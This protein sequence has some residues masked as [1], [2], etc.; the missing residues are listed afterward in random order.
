MKCWDG[1]LQSSPSIRGLGRGLAQRQRRLIN[2]NEDPGGARVPGLEAEPSAGDPSD[3]SD[4][5]PPCRHAQPVPH[6]AG[7]AHGWVGNSSSNPTHGGDRAVPMVHGE[8]LE[9]G[10]EGRM[11][12]SGSDPGRA[13]ISSLSSHPGRSEGGEVRP[14]TLSTH[15]SEDG[16]MLSSTIPALLPPCPVS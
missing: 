2:R 10:G 5:S 13:A 7:W 14:S 12:S 11:L 1:P 3:S 16:L 4:P 6:N 9:L 8:Q 15:G